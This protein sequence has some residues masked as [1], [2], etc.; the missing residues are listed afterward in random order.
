VDFF[1]NCAKMVYA[2]TRQDV[3]KM[4]HNTVLEKRERKVYKISYGWWS[5]LETDG[6]S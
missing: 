2:K 1:L 3:L 5:Q 6:H 4:V